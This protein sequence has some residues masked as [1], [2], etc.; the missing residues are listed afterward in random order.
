MYYFS[1]RKKK[2]TGILTSLGFHICK[3]GDRRLKSRTT[4]L[5]SYHVTQQVNSYNFTLVN[6][7]TLLLY[8]TEMFKMLQ[9]PPSCKRNIN[10]SKDVKLK[11]HCHTLHWTTPCLTKIY[12]YINN[13]LFLF[14]FFS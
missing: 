12:M 11:R 4:I 3:N 10:C 9:I 6:L 2:K 1:L 7:A 13:L 5:H 8:G 14:C